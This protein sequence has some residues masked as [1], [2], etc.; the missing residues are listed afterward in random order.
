MYRHETMINWLSEQYQLSDEPL[1]STITKI[2]RCVDKQDLM[3][4]IR[5]GGIETCPVCSR[6]VSV[7]YSYCPD[8]GQALK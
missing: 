8:C 6:S 4:T 5:Q 7:S 3:M 1:R 2:M